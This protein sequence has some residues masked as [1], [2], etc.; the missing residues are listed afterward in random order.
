MIKFRSLSTRAAGANGNRAHGII[1]PIKIV[2]AVA[3][4]VTAMEMS[5]APAKAAAAL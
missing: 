1:S 2:L 3:G 5:V 4:T